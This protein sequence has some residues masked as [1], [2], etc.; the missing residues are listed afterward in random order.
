MNVEPGAS[1]LDLC[2]APGGKSVM[3]ASMLFSGEPKT[4]RLV[5]NEMS[6]P[7]LQRLQ[8]VMSSFVPSEML[9]AGAAGVSITNVDAAAGSVPVPLQRLA[10]FDY[11]LV[12]APCTSVTRRWTENI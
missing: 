12:D 9:S 11:V 4:G 1:V 6:R 3:L 7:R 10:P 8:R 5:C 2:A